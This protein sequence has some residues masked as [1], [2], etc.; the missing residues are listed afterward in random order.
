MRCIGY[1]KR[2]SGKIDKCRNEVPV[3][4]YSK[5]CK[6]CRWKYA[7]DKINLRL[8]L[9]ENQNLNLNLPRESVNTFRNRSES[10]IR[11][12]MP[13]ELDETGLIDHKIES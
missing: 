6:V 3:N 10:Y 8:S 11:V 7:K 2:E 1:Y 5:I 4:D 12:Q 13:D 9:D